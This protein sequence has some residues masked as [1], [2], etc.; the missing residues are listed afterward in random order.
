MEKY[1][2]GTG[3]GTAIIHQRDGNGSGLWFQ[4]V[5][6]DKE[7]DVALYRI[8]GGLH[9]LQSSQLVKEQ[10]RRPQ[11]SLHPVTS[12]AVADRVITPGEPIALLGFP[13]GAFVTPVRQAV[14]WLLLTLCYW[15]RTT[16]L[17]TIAAR[18]SWCLSRGITETAVARY[19]FVDK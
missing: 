13:L 18:T 14:T 12:F 9:L 10:T 6:E 1:K 15:L 8:S 5:E 3:W 11:E 7:H 17:D 4:L 2:K 16:F 19:Q